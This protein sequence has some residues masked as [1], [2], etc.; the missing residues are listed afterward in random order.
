MSLQHLV[1]WGPFTSLTSGLTWHET[2]K[3][4][5]N[6]TETWQQWQS[7]VY[8]LNKSFRVEQISLCSNTWWWVAV[9][10]CFHRGWISCLRLYSTWQEQCN[11]HLNPFSFGSPSSADCFPNTLTYRPKETCKSGSIQEGTCPIPS[12]QRWSQYSTAIFSWLYVRMN[13]HY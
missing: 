6:Q 9:A 8:E 7:F 3:E 12:S 4:A 2:L 5:P 10:T 1:H 13:K 11:F